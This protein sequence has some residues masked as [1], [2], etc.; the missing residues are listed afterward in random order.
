[1]VGILEFACHLIFDTLHVS[2]QAALSALFI[3]TCLKW[4]QLHE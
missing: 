1:M 4:G 3:V 2:D